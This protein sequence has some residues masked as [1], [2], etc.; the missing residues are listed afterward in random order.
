VTVAIAAAGFGISTLPAQE[1]LGGSM[2]PSILERSPFIPPDF[3]PPGGA[4]AA[5]AA[6]GSVGGYEFRGVYQIGGEY[7][8]LVSEPRSR[9]GSWVQLGK[10]YDGYEVRKFDPGSDTLTLFF[11][12]SEQQLQLAELDANPTPMPVS[13]Q[14]KAATQPAQ[15]PATP[16]RRTIRPATRETTPSDAVTQPGST[17]PPAWL[18]K[19]REEAAARRSQAMQSRSGAGTAGVRA[20]GEPDFSPPP[21][22]DS[23]PPTPPPNLSEIDIPPPPTELPPPPPPEVMERIQQTISAGPPRG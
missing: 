2:E 14:I 4:R 16:A 17:P 1:V 22:P 19:L 15:T 13:G 12:N 9:K 6:Q 8:F 20:S 18:K 10:A 21:P 23:P 11:N 5:A 3:T 7:R